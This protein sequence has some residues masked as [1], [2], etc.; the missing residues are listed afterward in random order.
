MDRV[1]RA[2]LLLTAAGWLVCSCL[3]AHHHYIRSWWRK[4]SRFLAS[5]YQVCSA[6]VQRGLYVFAEARE[7]RKP[8]SHV[9]LSRS[10]SEIHSA[11]AVLLHFLHSF[12]AVLWSIYSHSRN[13]QK[14]EFKG[15]KV[16]LCKRFAFFPGLRCNPPFLQVV[17]HHTTSLYR[18]HMQVQRRLD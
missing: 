3:A 17:K 1:H 6:S 18:V 12:Y 4:L 16:C 2:E 15:L 9:E 10:H 13:P 11:A 5:D 14:L 7:Q 8:K